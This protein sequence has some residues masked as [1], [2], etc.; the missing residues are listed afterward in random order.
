MPAQYRSGGAALCNVVD[1]VEV[2]DRRTPAPRPIGTAHRHDRWRIAA[3]VIAVALGVVGTGSLVAGSPAAPVDA[4]NP[5][6]LTLATGQYPLWTLTTATNA[7]TVAGRAEFTGVFGMPSATFG[8]QFAQGGGLPPAVGAVVSTQSAGVWLSGA[9]PHPTPFGAVFGGTNIPITTGFLQVTTEQSIKPVTTITF[10]GDVPAG[11]FG[12]ALGDVDNGSGGGLD[13]ATLSATSSAGV[14]L[15]G[16]EIAG[17]VA[18]AAVPFNFCL[19]SNGTLISDRPAE[20][21]GPP[22]AQFVTPV[23]FPTTG[24]VSGSATPSTGSAVWFRP[25]RPLRTLSIVFENSGQTGVSTFDLWMAIL[26]ARITGSVVNTAGVPVANATVE[27]T[28]PV[29]L[30][31]TLS[32]QVTT[33][34][35]GEFDFGPV[36]ALAGY[37]VAVTASGYSP[38]LQ[39]G[40]DVSGQSR[41]VTLT[42]SAATGSA[43]TTVPT[44]S[45][46]APLPTVTP[47]APP[48]Q[49][50]TS[51]PRVLPTVGSRTP[52]G[53]AAVLA[54]LGLAAI[55]MARRAPTRR[56]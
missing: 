33:S 22:A 32:K 2:E 26:T 38:V 20:C 51:V 40:V 28:N 9:Q 49:P 47:T 53:L 36:V 3:L 54:G 8:V 5:R 56:S 52:F 25:S 27:L 31:S 34:A 6:A 15:T 16:A 41:F 50:T 55:V 44:T 29:N 43:T 45:S 24:V 13:N 12:F 48:L 23:W 1:I 14:A 39:P 46:T 4:T 7:A 30:A 11:P 17:F 19:E 35:T 21:N 42:L 18:T 37:S 10:N